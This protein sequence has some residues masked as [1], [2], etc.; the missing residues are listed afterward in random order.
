MT[1]TTVRTA[2]MTRMPMSPMRDPEACKRH[3]DDHE[4]Q[5]LGARREP[6]VGGEADAL[7]TRV[8][9]ADEERAGHGDHEREQREDR[10]G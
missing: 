4:D 6:D 3:A 2:R 10:V 7:R 8:R 9:V 5:A 1:V